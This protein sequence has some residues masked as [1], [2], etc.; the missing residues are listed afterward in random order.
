MLLSCLF[1]FV[2][3]AVAQNT[4][5]GTVVS[6]DDGDPIIGATVTIKGTK[7]ATVTDIDGHFSLVTPTANPTLE[8][9]YIGM[10]KQKTLRSHSTP[11]PTN[12]RTWW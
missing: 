2:G 3:I 6:G 8:V 10:K 5:T 9:T 1:L 12:W 7:T 11:M 4:V